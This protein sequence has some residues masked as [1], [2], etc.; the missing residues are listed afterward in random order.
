[1]RHLKS[2]IAAAS[3]AAA[4]TLTVACSGADNGTSA[5]TDANVDVSKLKLT[6][7]TAKAQGQVSTVNWML[8]DEPESLDLDTQGG[9]AGRTVL[10]NI[11]ERL[12]QLQ[13]DMSVRPF[14]AEKESRPDPKTLVLTL[15]NGVTFHDGAPMTAADVLYS[16]RRHAQPE[17]EQSDEFHNV[18]KM[19]R[20]GPREITISFKQPDALFTKALAGDAGL[21]Y[22]E[23]QVEKAGKEFGTPGQADACSGPYELT[24]WQSGDSIT[25]TRAPG[26]WGKKPLTTKVVFRWAADNA[27]V[28][29][30]TTHTADGTYADSINTVA[31]LRGKPGLDEH[32]GPSTATLALIPTERGGLADPDIRRA[33]SLAL[34]RAGI[35]KSGYSGLVEPWA[36]PVG[37]GAWGYEKDVFAAAQKK[38]TEAPA[39]PSARDIAKAKDLAKNAKDAPAGPIVIGT[40]S[41]QGRLVIANAVRAAL[42]QIGLKGQIKTVPTAEYG[43][44]Y[45]DKSARAGIDVLVADWYI[46]KSDP[47]GFYDNAISDSSDNW[48]GFRSAD[49]DRKVEQA[50]ATL[51]DKKRAALV[52]D[53]QRQFS[54]AKVWIPIAQQP[55]ALVI[56]DK[57]TGAPASM[58]YLY[59]PWAADLGA[60]KG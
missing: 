6:P 30:L 39:K 42:S 32:F 9:S 45:G 33:L 28:N 24:S 11:C 22:N 13:P 43:E 23:K 7:T 4:M 17:M 16:L 5:Q 55:T 56:N 8:E 31:A 19:T 15:R 53:I 2:G 46:S 12:Y 41:T 21:I 38:L 58:A 20:T 50:Q 51:D 60:K 37:S 14:L 36:A 59:Y 10:T 54:A 27:L 49:Y 34:D 44:Y 47:I 26:Y 52:V 18:S 35:A 1:M 40:D 3:L 25:I 29:T 57:L 48:I